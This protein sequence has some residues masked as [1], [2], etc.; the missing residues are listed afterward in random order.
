MTNMQKIEAPGMHVIYGLIDP[1]D[2]SVHY[3]GLTKDAF[4][5]FFQHIQCSGNNYAKNAWMHELRAA[6][7]VPIMKTL[8]ATPEY[9]YALLREEYWI[10]HYE[11]LGE[12]LR[13]EERRVGKEC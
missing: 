5:R 11:T 1:R 4:S 3:V 8:E 10:G 6:N 9:D 2:Q 13:S 12:P 7:V